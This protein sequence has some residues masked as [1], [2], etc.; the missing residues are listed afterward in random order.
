MNLTFK[1]G[2]QVLCSATEEVIRLR[3]T[4]SFRDGKI[5]GFDQSMTGVCGGETREL[6]MKIGG[7]PKHGPPRPAGNGHF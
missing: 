5:E 2:D 4:L 6:S 3:P 1:Y 7:R